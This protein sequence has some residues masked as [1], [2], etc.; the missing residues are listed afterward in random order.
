MLAQVEKIR[1]DTSLIRSKKLL[2]KLKGID[3]ALIH[4]KQKMEELKL[5]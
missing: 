5:I 1:R 2:H 4:Y 3:G